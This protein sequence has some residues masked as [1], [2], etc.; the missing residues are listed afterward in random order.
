MPEIILSILFG[1]VVGVEAI[2]PATPDYW[3]ILIGLVVLARV[4]RKEAVSKARWKLCQSINQAV[5]YKMIKK[6][7]REE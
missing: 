6:K 3:I 7:E 5:G 2:I 1:Y 4:Q